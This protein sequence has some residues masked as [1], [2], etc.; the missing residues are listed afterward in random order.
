MRYALS[1]LH[2]PIVPSYTN[3]QKHSVSTKTESGS[4]FFGPGRAYAFSKACINALTRILARENPGLLINAC[5]PGWVKTD[6]GLSIGR[7]PK[8]AE[9]GAKIPVRLA[10]DD[11]GS[12]S[13]AYWANASVRSKED[14]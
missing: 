9:D 12:V 1:S 11:I 5:C 10:L 8:T 6:M 14:G 13:G 7:A 2:L 4:G 3:A